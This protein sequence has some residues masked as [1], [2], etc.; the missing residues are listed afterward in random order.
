MIPIQ[1]K[2]IK[3]KLSDPHLKWAVGIG[4]WINWT[5]ELLDDYEKMATA[6]F[7]IGKTNSEYDA[8]IAKTTLQ[9]IGH[10]EYTKD[11]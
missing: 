8:R 2:T 10:K 1:I 11:G 3:T 5:E 6:L 9:D 4:D 7:H